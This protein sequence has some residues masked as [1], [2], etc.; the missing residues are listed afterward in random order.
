MT[1]AMRRRALAAAL[2]A[3]LAAASCV[4]EMSSRRTAPGTSPL[5]ATPWTPPP[6]LTPPPAPPPAVPPA[7]ASEEGA[8]TANG[9]PPDLLA[10]AANWTLTDLL[11]LAL[12]NAPQTRIAWAQARSAAAALGAE[13]G[14]YYP[15]VVGQVNAARTKASAVG[16]QF[17]YLN[18]SYDPFLQINWLLLDFG[19]R[20]N[21]V[22]SARQALIAADWSHNAA[23]QDVVLEV[24]QAYYGYLDARALEAAERVAV[25]EATASLDAAERRRASGVST[26]AD[27]LRAK[28]SLSQAQ[29]ALQTV[30]GQIHTIHGSLATAVGLPADTPFEVT[31]PLDEVPQEEASVQVDRAIAEAQ[32]RRP[33]LAA[34]R[35]RVEKASADVR[36]QA[37]LDRPTL[38]LSTNSGRIYYN[39]VYTGQDT[40]TASVLLTIP[41]FN[42]LTYQYNVHKAKADRD[43]AQAQLDSLAQQ[44]ILDVWTSYYD[45]QTAAQQVKTSRDLLESARQASEVVAA[46][47][48]AGVGSILDVLTAQGALD[49]ARALETQART[50]WFVTLARLAHATGTLWQPAP[51]AASQTPE[52]K[53]P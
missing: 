33:D 53:T 1:A 8:T 34:A 36:A 37:S 16:G 5:P 43:A 32:A 25:E 15:A 31:L 35:A 49:R 19:G 24:Q 47:Y 12:R 41:I 2:L 28:T 42:G 17:T 7:A 13:K 38:N 11:D 46:R 40:Y 9:I 39:Q 14:G 29:L 18:T 45:H 3:A 26:I 6:E 30:Q 21:N 22:E 23:I 44:V 27:V 52:D 50:A 51:G 10:N 48:K 20:S 4:H